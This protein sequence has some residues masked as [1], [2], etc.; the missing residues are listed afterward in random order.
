MNK[1]NA[2]EI[3]KSI[4]HEIR[5]PMNGIVGAI[6]LLQ[7]TPLTTQQ[8]NIM[9]IMRTSSDYMLDL[10]SNLFNIN[11]LNVGSNRLPKEMVNLLDLID[12]VMLI[13][14]L[15]AKKKGLMLSTL[16]SADIPKKGLINQVSL[17]QI[18]I[19][20]IGNA[21][22]FTSEG[23]ITVK[24]GIEKK[25]LVFDIIDTGI[26]IDISNQTK[27]FEP[28]F[29]VNLNENGCGLGLSISSKLVKLMNGKIKIQSQLGK[30]SHFK[31]YF[32]MEVKENIIE[33]FCSSITAP[34]E[35]HQQL[36]LWKITPKL[37]ENKLLS[38]PDL[39][40]LP[41]RLHEKLFRFTNK[42][43]ENMH[44]YRYSKPCL[45]SLKILIVDDVAIN[46]NIMQLILQSMGHQVDLA[47]SGSMA[48][49]LGKKNIYDMVLMDLNMPRRDGFETLLLWRKLE[50]EILDN[51]TPI[52]ATTAD[53]N[54]ADCSS[55]KS[56]KFNDY[57]TKPFKLENLSEIIDKVII[58]Q[59][60]RGI[61]LTKNE[62][63]SRS[64]ININDCEGFNIRLKITFEKF[65]NQVENIWYKRQ[66]N[67]FL[68]VLH[69][70]KGCA[71]LIGIGDVYEFCQYLE[72]KVKAGIWS[73]RDKQLL[74]KQISQCY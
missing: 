11:V 62:N 66:R 19:N 25:D 10:I 16:I 52:I 7:Q 47:S 48:I 22:K 40:F 53:P 46:Q 41:G 14:N 65:Y 56:V 29:K 42:Y 32:P 74:L 69:S 18:L 3:S 17:M 58:S 23:S 31:L 24:V 20:L 8:K 27:I 63:T 43:K 21:I 60:E 70:I 34:I 1:G 51:E 2:A 73:E 64:I 57:L 28:F 36:R 54:G 37:G 39:V 30:G 38:C 45:W 35:L 33:D 49:D 68:E 5:T 13:V 61:E 6:E 50:N 26:G 55:L 15:D 59:L 9:E 71:A 12:R 67:S 44:R 4:T 72:N